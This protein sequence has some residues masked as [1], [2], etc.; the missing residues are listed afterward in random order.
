MSGE[1][2]IIVWGFVDW[3]SVL[4]RA[5][6]SASSRR[7]HTRCALGT[8]VQ[9]CALPI[10]IDGLELEAP[11]RVPGEMPDA[12]AQMIEQRPGPA[13]QQDAAED[14]AVEALDRELGSASCRERVC[15]YV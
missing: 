6:L 7:R 8:G 15:P 11:A 9:T 4:R 13:E 2:L 10:C 3:Y 5:Y 1:M 14:G 12:V